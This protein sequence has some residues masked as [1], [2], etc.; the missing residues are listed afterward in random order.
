LE[1]RDELQRFAAAALPVSYD[2]LSL[3][4]PFPSLTQFIP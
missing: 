1:G 2:E 4:G 3:Q